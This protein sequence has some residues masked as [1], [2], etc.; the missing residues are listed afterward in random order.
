MLTMFRWS[1]EARSWFLLRLKLLG[2]GS[3]NRLS[4]TVSQS[5][6]KPKSPLTIGCLNFHRLARMPHHPKPNHLR[7]ALRKARPKRSGP[8]RTSRSLRE[9][10]RLS[11]L[12]AQFAPLFR[13]HRSPMAQLSSTPKKG[14]IIHPGDTLHVDLSVDPA[15]PVKAAAI[16]SPMGDSNEIREG[17]PYSFTFSAVFERLPFAQW[18][19]WQ[20]RT[21]RLSTQQ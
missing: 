16:I 8:M 21:L 14:E 17:P 2:S 13:R 5:R 20:P 15:I 4:Q 1:A 10:F 12:P 9:L 19:Q 6:S 7:L 11:Q 18:S 3:S